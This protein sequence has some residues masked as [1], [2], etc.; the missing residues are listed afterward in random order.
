MAG[1]LYGLKLEQKLNKNFK[2]NKPETAK[3]SALLQRLRKHL[4]FA[5]VVVTDGATSESHRLFKVILPDLRHW[6]IL[7]HLLQKKQLS[8]KVRSLKG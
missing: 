7:F 1:F 8:V 5:N 3:A 4:I 2:K 6:I